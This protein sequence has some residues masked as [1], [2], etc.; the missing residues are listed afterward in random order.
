M[1][2]ISYDLE[3]LNEWP[4]Q[5]QEA[6][7][8][9]Q[10]ERNDSRKLGLTRLEKLLYRPIRSHLAPLLYDKE[11]DVRLSALR[12]L[13]TLFDSQINV[14]DLSIWEQVFLRLGDTSPIVHHH[15]SDLIGKLAPL[16][17]CL[18][19]PLVESNQSF[20]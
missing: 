3:G 17:T 9:T 13:E 12:T 10:S 7:A 6:F 11:W 1:K 18:N 15:T 16:S 20:P 2:L 8:L 14:E 19:R 5:V 4:V